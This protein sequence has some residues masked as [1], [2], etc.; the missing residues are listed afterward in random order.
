MLHV[1]LALVDPGIGQKFLSL[2]KNSQM[3]MTVS[4]K[5]FL[6]GI[7]DFRTIRPDVTH[8]T[9][10]TSAPMFDELLQYWST[11]TY[12]WEQSQ[13][14]ETLCHVPLNIIAAEWVNYIAAMGF[15]LRQYTSPPLNLKF[16]QSDLNQITRALASLESWSRRVLSSKEHINATL[17]FVEYRS[18]I[19]GGEKHT[20]HEWG[21][22][23]EDYGQIQ[24]SLVEYGNLLAGAMSTVSS[25]LQLAEGRRALSEARNISRLTVLALFFLPLGYVSSLFSMNASFGPGGPFFW[26]YFVVAIP[27]SLLVFGV[28]RVMTRYHGFH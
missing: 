12:N 16:S 5:P 7:E 23:L 19:E 2:R 13:A 14:F 17:A 3:L 20:H 26:I 11:S 22:L 18:M 8:Q 21:A 28:A 10:S 6:G 9:Q 24:V 15:S 27:V 1:G 4:T 25:Y